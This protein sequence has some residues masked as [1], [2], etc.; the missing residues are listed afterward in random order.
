MKKKNFFFC[1]FILLLCAVS[2][3]CCKKHLVMQLIQFNIS[4]WTSYH[5]GS[6]CWNIMRVIQHFFLYFPISGQIYACKKEIEKQD[7]KK[8]KSIGIH[9]KT[10][11]V[12]NFYLQMLSTKRL[13]FENQPIPNG[14]HFG[15][16]DHF[17]IEKNGIIIFCICPSFWPCYRVFFPA[18]KHTQKILQKRKLS[19]ILAI[20]FRSLS[21]YAPFTSF[22]Y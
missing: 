2:L 21:E 4:F 20:T 8:T 9:N 6:L 3:S 1:L 15:H 11:F 17:D 12:S 13:Q 14:C 19:K 16:F 7:E 22:I 10:S 18:Q 5:C